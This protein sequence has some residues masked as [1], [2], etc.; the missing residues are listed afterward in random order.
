M[1]DILIV[2]YI[3]LCIVGAAFSIWSANERL[4]DYQVAHLTTASREVLARASF[5]REVI[6]TMVHIS[7]ALFATSVLLEEGRLF[8]LVFG[9]A[10]PVLLTINSIDAYFVRKNFNK[11]VIK[12]TIKPKKS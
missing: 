9:M 10:S 7:S 6:K 3:F 1:V 5:R 11:L 4:E 8:V 12:E 2:I